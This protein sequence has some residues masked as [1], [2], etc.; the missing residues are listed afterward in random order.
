MAARG[1]VKAD[2][3]TFDLAGLPKPSEMLGMEAA[4][5][6]LIKALQQQWRVMIVADFDS[7][8]ATS[9]AVMMRGLRMMGLQHIDFIVPNRFVHGYGLT[10]EL[11]NEIDSETQPDLLITVD[12]GIASLDG[13][14][15]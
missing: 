1:I 3:L 9:C 14:A 8:G 10:T 11:L 12:N 6:L 4:V 15:L 5:T 7:D 2:E 13:V